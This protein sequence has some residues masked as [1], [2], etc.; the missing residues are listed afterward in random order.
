M[1]TVAKLWGQQMFSARPTVT[2]HVKSYISARR[3]A[4]GTIDCYASGRKVHLVS[5]WPSAL[6]FWTQN[7]INSSEMHW[8]Y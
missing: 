2:G 3:S 1:T 8:S 7:L 5:L 4:T 6:A